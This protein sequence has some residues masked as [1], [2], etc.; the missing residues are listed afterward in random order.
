MPKKKLKHPIYVIQKHDARALHYDFRLEYKGKLKSWAIPKGPSCNPAEKRLSLPTEDH[1]LSHAT[2]EGVIPEGEYG[3]GTVMVWDIGTF[4]NIKTKDGKKVSLDKSFKSGLIEIWLEGERLKG[5]YAMVRIGTG[6]ELRWLL[7][8]M[9]DE[10]ASRRRNPV[11]TQNKSVL[12][13][14]TMRAITRDAKKT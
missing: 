7:V 5:G 4:R 12:T 1:A 10:E 8:K 9:D 11:N 3:A 2:F 14:R 6:K 13:G